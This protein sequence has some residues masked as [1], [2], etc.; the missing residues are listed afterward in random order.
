MMGV[1]PLFR[2]SYFQVVSWIMIQ[3]R[4]GSVSC[5]MSLHICCTFCAVGVT[6]LN[7]LL[8]DKTVPEKSSNTG[9]S[10]TG[11]TFSTSV[12]G[13][14]FIDIQL[15]S[16]PFHLLWNMCWDFSSTSRNASNTWRGI[17]YLWIFQFGEIN[18]NV[19]FGSQ[20]QY[21]CLIPSSI[22]IGF[23]PGGHAWTSVSCLFTWLL[24][25]VF[26]FVTNPSAVVLSVWIGGWW[27]LVSHFFKCR[28]RWYC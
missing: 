25:N 16:T 13:Y 14:C 12:Y 6:V 11:N 23:Y 5:C 26:F 4:S 15:S 2:L 27:L 28:L 24:L 17:R 9:Y 22:L 19:W 8:L 10:R 21:N 1:E 20:N 3:I 18:K 7:H